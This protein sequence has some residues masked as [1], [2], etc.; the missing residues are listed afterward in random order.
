MKKSIPTLK[1]A[2][3]FSF[4]ASTYLPDSALA[5]AFSDLD[6]QTQRP[7]HSQETL[8]AHYQEIRLSVPHLSRANT[9]SFYY[10]MQALSLG[11]R[12]T[13]LSSTL[14]FQQKLRSFSASVIDSTEL[15]KGF[16]SAEN[17]SVLPEL[18]HAIN[19]C[20]GYFATQENAL[21]LE[22]LWVELEPFLQEFASFKNTP[23]RPLERENFEK[24]H[25]LLSRYEAINAFHKSIAVEP[26]YSLLRIAQ[27]MSS[28]QRA[29]P[30]MLCGI[31]DTQFGKVAEDILYKFSYST[32][33]ESYVRR[34]HVLDEAQRLDF[35]NYYGQLSAHAQAIEPYEGNSLDNLVELLE[36]CMV[37][38][39]L[40]PEERAHLQLFSTPTQQPAASKSNS[41]AH[42]RS[43]KGRGRASK[44]SVTQQTVASMRADIAAHLLENA[45]INLAMATDRYAGLLDLEAFTP[46]N[47]LFARCLE[48]YEVFQ[49]AHT[50]RASSS[51][52]RTQKPEPISQPLVTLQKL[53]SDMQ[54]AHNTLRE[55]F[56]AKSVMLAATRIQDPEPHEP[57]SFDISTPVQPNMRSAVIDEHIKAG[58]LTS[59]AKHKPKK[60]P[61]KKNGK[62]KGK[63]RS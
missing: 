61:K 39:R 59:A 41:R 57:S 40:A 37:Y 13:R 12:T 62:N 54:D 49:P 26:L 24:A 5:S 60:G 56:R 19:G 4:L 22:Y 51:S 33:L 55:A 23:L 63:R 28:V 14:T 47:A 16:L 27:D 7:F 9:D 34:L 46:I 8:D 6:T 36:F 43:S 18:K 58:N 2:L 1:T 52:S 15:S 29:K 20:A 31:I 53:L 45:R 48:A 11:I 3:I 38:T 21:F 25:D 10:T 44:R 35:Y 17:S 32:D 50:T 30:L 42:A